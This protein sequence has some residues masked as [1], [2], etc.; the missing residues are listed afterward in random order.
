MA[1][2]NDGGYI[3]DY[4]TMFAGPTTYYN[5]WDTIHNMIVV[6]AADEMGT[7]PTWSMTAD[8]LTTYSPG[9]DVPLPDE[10]LE[11]GDD[12]MEIHEGTSYGKLNL[13]PPPLLGSLGSPHHLR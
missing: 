13:F 3:N 1:A 7:T 11:H 8:Y 9:E 5:P 10:P 6:G 12:P 2:G 4:P